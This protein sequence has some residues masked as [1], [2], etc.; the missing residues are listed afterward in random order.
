M[1][2]HELAHMK[3]L[4][5]FCTALILFDMTDATLRTFH[6]RQLPSPA[7]PF[8]SLEGRGLFQKALEQGNLNGYFRLSETYSTQ[9]YWELLLLPFM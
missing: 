4:L 8:S 5:L 3:M 2:I 6:R 7:V 9:G 1:S